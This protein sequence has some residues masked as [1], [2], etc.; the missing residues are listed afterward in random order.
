MRKDKENGSKFGVSM[1]LTQ[2]FLDKTGKEFYRHIGF[3]VYEEIGPVL[4]RPAHKRYYM[5]K[6]LVCFCFGYTE[7]DIMRDVR[8]NE[9]ASSILEKIISE[10]KNGTCNCK[11]NHPEGR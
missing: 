7:D 1:I 8:E 9:G 6:N 2:V 5:K 10:K 11:F 3:Y 4:K